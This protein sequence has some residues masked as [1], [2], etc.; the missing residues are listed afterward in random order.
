MFH[1]MRL[2]RIDVMLL[3]KTLANRA[4]NISRAMTVRCYLV[5][6]CQGTR[7]WSLSQQQQTTALNAQDPMHLSALLPCMSVSSSSA[8]L[9]FL[10]ISLTTCH[11]RSIDDR[12]EDV[13]TVEFVSACI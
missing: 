4:N 11:P 3:H 13:T 9:P 7:F 1:Y 5:R 12:L 8:S 6:T 10:I 2:P